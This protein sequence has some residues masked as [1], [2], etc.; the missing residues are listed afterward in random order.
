MATYEKLT[1]KVL[2]QKITYGWKVGFSH[3]E[4]TGIVNGTLTVATLLA[5]AGAPGAVISTVLTITAG[6][7]KATDQ[8]G[9]NQ[10]V[11]ITFIFATGTPVPTPKGFVDFPDGEIPDSMIPDYVLKDFQ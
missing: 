9:G 3:D 4:V 5:N 10:G 8:L 2:G 7:L 1:K 11:D 6:V